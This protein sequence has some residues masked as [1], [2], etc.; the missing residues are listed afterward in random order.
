MLEM[1]REQLCV[2]LKWRRGPWISK[3]LG[4]LDLHRTAARLLTVSTILSSVLS[5]KKAEQMATLA[6]LLYKGERACVQG[7]R[8][9]RSC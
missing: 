4:S 5:L 2:G 1:G 3:F 7:A 8:R 6:R 9:P